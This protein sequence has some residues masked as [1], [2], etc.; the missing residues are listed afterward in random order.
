MASERE[1]VAEI[2]KR[3]RWWYAHRSLRGVT[4]ASTDVYPPLMAL[5]Q[6]RIERKA[7]RWIAEE[8]QDQAARTN[9]YTIRAPGAP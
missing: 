3:G 5:T 6:K 7:R 2:H 9:D 8:R 4:W 1:P